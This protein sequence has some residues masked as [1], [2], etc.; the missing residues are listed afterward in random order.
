MAHGV[1]CIGSTVQSIPEI[2]DHGRAGLLVEPG[3]EQ[4]L[5][6]ALLR[7][8]SDDELAHRLGAAGQREVERR[9]TWDHVVERAAPPLTAAATEG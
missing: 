3:D 2:L 5:A 1:P 8:L 7:L 4:A 6:Q 9:L